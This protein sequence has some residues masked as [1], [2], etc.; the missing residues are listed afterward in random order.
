MSKRRAP[1][2][3][4]LGSKKTVED[5][6][7]GVAERAA[8]AR[9]ERPKVGDIASASKAFD[10]RK[11]SAMTVQQ[12]VTAQQTIRN[13]QGE[14]KASPLSDQTVE[15]LKA[16][17]DFSKKAWQQKQEEVK[18][19]PERSEPEPTPE[20][21]PPKTDHRAVDALNNMDDYELE[22]LLRN[23]QNDVI[24]NDAE[25][26][27]VE[28]GDRC[29]PVDL[30]DALRNNE[31]T[32]RVAIVPRVLEVTFRTL[33][34]VEQQGIRTW[35]FNMA[36]SAADASTREVI[37]RN[38]PEIY[39]LAVA[40]AT[41]VQVNKTPRPSHMVGQAYQEVFD[42]AVFGK[43]YEEFVRYPLPLIHAL[44]THS[45]WFDLRMRKMFTSDSLK[46]G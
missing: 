9:S 8:T 41:I 33:S 10:P 32:Q 16:T 25:R 34:A 2:F 24:N 38:S 18:M 26:E 39:S 40:V 14:G 46:N 30:A 29:S 23:L 12:V 36:M 27:A 1:R 7:R 43:K 5:Y 11:D 45:A 44:Y 3:V 20:K 37:N 28:K 22:R 19:E 15:V 13:S 6:R 4:D 42:E 31:F 17:A 35:I 21:E